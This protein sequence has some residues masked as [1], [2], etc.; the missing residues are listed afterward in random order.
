VSSTS[1]YNRYQDLLKILEEIN[2]GAVMS[3]SAKVSESSSAKA[4]LGLGPSASTRRVLRASPAFVSARNSVTNLARGGN[5]DAKNPLV[6]QPPLSWSVPDITNGLPMGKF[7]IHKPSIR[8]SSLVALPS[9]EFASTP[10]RP[11]AR[12]YGC[13][14]NNQLRESP[15]VGFRSRL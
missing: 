8:L 9:G 10:P 12:T 5:E 6:V 14:I 15:R 1:P 3:V 11:N 2:P 13:F 4:A 7:V